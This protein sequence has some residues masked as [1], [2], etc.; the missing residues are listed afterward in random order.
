[1]TADAA[2]F[3][4][5]NV[6]QPEWSTILEIEPGTAVDTRLALFNEMVDSGMRGAFYHFTFPG[7]GNIYRT[8][9]GFGY[10]PIRYN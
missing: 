10:H 4:F 8:E 7:I 6:E 5:L 9:S 2:I 1:M 3:E